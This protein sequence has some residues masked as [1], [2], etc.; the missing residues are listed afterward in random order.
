MVEENKLTPEEIDSEIDRVRDFFDKIPEALRM[1][2]AYDFIMEIV[3]W[4][5]YCHFDALGILEEVKMT[6]R[7]RYLEAISEG[8][9]DEKEDV[10]P[11]E[12]D[13]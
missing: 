3:I 7:E 4:G 12:E 9:E 11:E 1:D 5:S 2:A 13:K 6:Y 8:E 10:L